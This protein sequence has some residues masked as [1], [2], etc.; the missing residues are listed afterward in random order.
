[1]GIM[2]EV[3]IMTQ[4]EKTL[5]RAKETAERV[6]ATKEGRKAARLSDGEP[7]LEAITQALFGRDV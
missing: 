1:M 5:Q 6:A 2:G 3:E 4:A 7:D